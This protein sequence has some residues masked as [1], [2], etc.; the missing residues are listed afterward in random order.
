MHADSFSVSRCILVP[1]F[2]LLLFPFR[3]I[4]LLGNDKKVLP[5]AAYRWKIV[6]VLSHHPL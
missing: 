5:T 2:F 1:A 4:R 6:S 3:L